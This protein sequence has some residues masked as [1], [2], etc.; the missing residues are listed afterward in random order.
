MVAEEAAA[1][2]RLLMELEV[3]GVRCSATPLVVATLHSSCVISP[4]VSAMILSVASAACTVPLPLSLLPAPI[5]HSTLITP[6][7]GWAERVSTVN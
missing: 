3:S 7:Q 2:P 6:E 1:P 5:F 4:K